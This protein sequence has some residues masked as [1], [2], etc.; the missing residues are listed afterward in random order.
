[1]ESKDTLKYYPILEKKDCIYTSCYCEENVYQICKK[2]VDNSTEF[3]AKNEN[4]KS[5]SFAVFITNKKKQA[6]I[7]YQKAGAGNLHNTVCWYY[8]C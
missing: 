4:Y 5:E 2:V 8:Y 1:M 7:R 3:N 6:E